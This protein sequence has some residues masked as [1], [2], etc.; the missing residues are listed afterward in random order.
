[1]EILINPVHTIIFVTS[2]VAIIIS[3]MVLIC[4]KK[5]WVY[6][7]GPLTYFINLFIYNL[8]LHLTY[9]SHLGLL[10]FQQAEFWSGVVRLHSLFL[11]ISYVIVQPL[12][13]K[14]I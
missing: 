3:I 7:I 1:M 10:T 6:I 13:R 12:I 5:R 2:F 11:F 14:R 8:F 4:Y 9:V